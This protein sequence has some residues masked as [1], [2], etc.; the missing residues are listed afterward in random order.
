MA[1]SNNCPNCDTNIDEGLNSV[2][3]EM[4]DFIAEKKEWGQFSAPVICFAML[5]AV[6]DVVFHVAPSKAEAQQVV[7]DVNALYYEKGDCANA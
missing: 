4:H 3:E 5:E 1:E 6:M 7:D 2:Y